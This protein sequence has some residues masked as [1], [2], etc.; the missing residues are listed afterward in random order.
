MILAANA[1]AARAA[2]A[3]PNGPGIV[4]A[5]A[6][7]LVSVGLVESLARPGDRI[8]GLTTIGPQLSGKRLELLRYLR[9]GLAR[10]A[11]LWQPS[12]PLHRAAHRE[13]QAAAGALGL[14]LVSLEF[15]PA[16]DL[17]A[18]FQ[19][20]VRD[21]AEGIVVFGGPQGVRFTDQIV[22]LA[23]Q[24]SLPAVYP[25]RSFVVAGGLLSYGPDLGYQFQRAAQYVDK[26]LRGAK[27]S[28]LPV[29]QPTRFEFVLN[30]TA[31][32][33]IGLVIPWELLLDATEVIQ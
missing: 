18:L 17:A 6:G 31:A 7:D 14:E 20:A 12:A 28:T 27:P 24:Y 3:I 25:L 1:G 26:I 5:G 33:A 10:A 29:E 19:R 22:G 30:V 23:A 11:V 15:A 32:Q 16:D 13:T 4:V 9:P 8:T 2:L 21:G